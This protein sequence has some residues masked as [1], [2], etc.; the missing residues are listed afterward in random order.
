MVRHFP[1]PVAQSCA[2]SFGLSVQV[3]PPSTLQEP[4][5]PSPL[6][7]LPSS[8]SSPIS[9][10]PLPQV[11]SQSCV[12]PD[13]SRHFGSFVQVLEQPVPS[14]KKRP[15]GPAHPVGSLAGSVP[16]SQPSL[17]SFTPLPQTAT[18]HFPP[19]GGQV[20]PG[21]GKQ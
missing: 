5:Q 16:Q 6:S 10:L 3:K 15:F 8:Q 9:L 4:S 21:S 19:V 18:V 17:D 13:E 14:P 11:V 2:S 7:R 1:P 12:L 20:A